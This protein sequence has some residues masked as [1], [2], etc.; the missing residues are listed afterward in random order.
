MNNASNLIL[1]TDVNNFFTNL[2]E[3]TVEDIIEIAKLLK[4]SPV[5]VF[6]TIL[7][8]IEGD[9]IIGGEPSE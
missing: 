8:E 2:S 1:E 5:E 9:E 4:K 7:S 6:E 3:L